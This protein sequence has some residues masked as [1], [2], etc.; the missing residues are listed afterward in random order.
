MLALYLSLADS[1]NEKDKVKA[2]YEQYHDLLMYVAAQILGQQEDAEDAVHQA[3]LSIIKNLHKIS[4]VECPK[5]RAYC[6]IIVRNICFNILKR[7]KRVIPTDSYEEWTSKLVSDDISLFVENSVLTQA[8]SKLNERYRT[9]LY[10]KYV[11]GFST[12][13]IAKAMDIKPDTVLKLLSRARAALSK[14]YQK[15]E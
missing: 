14:E 9:V 1:P 15:N 5:T 2:L 10:L 6:V 11:Q 3:F 7:R 13:E 12:S 4:E 8:L